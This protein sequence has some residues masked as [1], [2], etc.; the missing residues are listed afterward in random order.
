MA[1]VRCSCGRQYTVADKLIG[2]RV[3]CGACKQMFVA[4]AVAP[5]ARPKPATGATRRAAPRPG[6]IGELAIARGLITRE[7]LDACLEYQEVIHKLPG[8]DDQR[9]GQILVAKRLLSRAQ[10]K[11]LVAGQVN[12]AA[13]A[14]AAAEGM[15]ARRPAY[16]EAVT[17][18]QRASLRRVVEDA[19]R[20]KAVKRTQEPP[21]VVQRLSRIRPAHVGIAAAIAL[22][23]LL[24]VKL[25]P[26]PA[27][28]RTL[29]AYLESSDE[30]A[31]TPDASLALSDLGLAI[32]E[33]GDL[34][35]LPP[36]VFDY[37]A[38]LQTFAGQTGSKT[39]PDLIENVEMAPGK[40]HALGLLLDALSKRTSP[41]TLTSLRVTVQPATCRLAFRRRGMGAVMEGRYRFTLVNVDSPAWSSGWKVAA[42]TPTA[43]VR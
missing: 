33:F 20:Q 36:A 14:N 18:E 29:A 1:K 8:Q 2:Q 10:V 38:E 12:P 40:R 26:A 5:P 37:T 19:S 27:A 6:R 34:E 4:T 9:L 17:E 3:R 13:Q 15:T 16:R 7:Q 42:F 21:A 22:A 30:D 24:V 31:P 25:R 43:S 11:A 39:W 32:R 35:L 41:R 28:Q 23:A